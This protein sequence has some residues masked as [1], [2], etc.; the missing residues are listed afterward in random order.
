MAEYGVGQMNRLPRPAAGRH[1]R[2]DGEGIE[3][4]MQ[5]D[6]QKGSQSKQSEAV[7]AVASATTAAPRATPSIK[8]CSESPSAR[9]NQL[10]GCWPPGA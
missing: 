9:P 4:L 1:Q 8:V 2:G 7:L 6:G 10:N 5:G 3:R